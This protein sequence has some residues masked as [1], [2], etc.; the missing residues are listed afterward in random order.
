MLYELFQEVKITD[1]LKENVLT[2]Y[3]GK[4]PVQS[5]SSNRLLCEQ[6]ISF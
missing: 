6:N 5:V 4:M 3:L 2:K 1:D